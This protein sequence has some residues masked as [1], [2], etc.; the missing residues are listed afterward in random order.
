[1][2]RETID[3]ELAGCRM[4]LRAL[5]GNP[6]ARW[7]RKLPPE[8]MRQPAEWRGA[9]GSSRGV[10]TSLFYQQLGREDEERRARQKANNANHVKSQELWRE[11]QRKIREEERARKGHDKPLYA[12]WKKL[13]REYHGSETG[14][15]RNIET[16]GRAHAFNHEYGNRR[17]DQRDVYDKIKNTEQQM[18]DEGIDFNPY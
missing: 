1:M 4:E 11:G 14:L 13:I 6:F 12:E 18:R 9:P 3:A 16:N 8:R 7:N 5:G 15:I 10:D 2:R 17:S